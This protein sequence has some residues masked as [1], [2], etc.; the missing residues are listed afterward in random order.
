MEKKEIRI[1]A[2]FCAVLLVL[3]GYILLRYYHRVSDYYATVENTTANDVS[4]Y[5][6]GYHYTTTASQLTMSEDPDSTTSRKTFIHEVYTQDHQDFVTVTVSI[7]GNIST[8]NGTISHISTS[9]SES[10]MDGLTISEHL[11]GET[12]TVVLYVNQIS[13]C[14]FQYRLSADGSID[15]LSEQ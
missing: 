6:T 9:L 11:T 13:V 8:E 7:T 15:F 12:A 3:A 1:L 10:L 14:H 2:L 5:L 4:A